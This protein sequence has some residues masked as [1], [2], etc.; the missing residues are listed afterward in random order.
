M[1]LPL[2]PHLLNKVHVLPVEP[3]S[4]KNPADRGKQVIESGRIGKS[5]EVPS[6]SDSGSKKKHIKQRHVFRTKSEV[7]TLE[8]GYRWRKYGQ[9]GV[10]NSPYT[11]SYYRCT[12]SRCPVKKRVE[13]DIIDPSNVITTYEGVHNHRS[14][15]TIINALLKDVL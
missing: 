15:G 11:R 5:L 7:D 9:K 4:V 10:K 8:D 3:S 2:P 14:I 12:A 1:L 6:K 13:R